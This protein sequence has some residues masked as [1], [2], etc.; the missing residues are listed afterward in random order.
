[1]L[2]STHLRVSALL[3]F[4][5]ALSGFALA[6]PTTATPTYHLGATWKLAGDSFWDYLTVD[7][8]MHRL[9]IPRDTRIQVLDTR[10]GALVGQV[11]GLARAHGVALVPSLG[12]GFVTSGGQNSVVCFDL[13]TLK[14]IGTPIRVG[15]GPDAI[16][17]EPSTGRVFALNG[18]GNSAS[19][20]NATSR[21][22]IKTIALGSNPESAAVDGQ[23]QVFVNI[24]GTSKLAQLDAKTLRVVHVWPL[25]P[26]EGPTGL[27][28]SPQAARLFSACANQQVIV[29]SAR[30]GAVQARLPIGAGVD[31][32]AFDPKLGLAFT[33]NGQSGTISIVGQNAKG[34]PIVVATLPTHK[35]ARTMALDPQTHSLFVVA[36]DYQPKKPGQRYP[37][38]VPGT[39]VVLRYDL[40]AK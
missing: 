30:T 40:S 23:G 32:A 17:F 14:P 3:G 4:S 13:R 25:A 36:A 10:T 19:V 21:K 1:M 16:A 12:R 2:S 11:T 39:A 7:P 37:E 27:A 33:S 29:L 18:E 22:V 35:G 28:Y 34:Q 24:E 15:N 26:G 38:I 6:A 31:A 8:A 5:A 20:I 9:Y